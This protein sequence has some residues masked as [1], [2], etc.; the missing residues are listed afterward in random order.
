M[1]AWIIATLGL[2]SCMSEADLST[3]TDDVTVP[4]QRGTDRASA[5][6]VAEA[7]NLKT[8]HGVKWTGVYIGGP[9]SAGSGWTKAQVTAI[10]NATGWTF[11]PTYVG[12]QSSA[13]CGAHTLTQAQGT[14]D[15]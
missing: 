9:C 5:F 6:S 1:R 4:V 3:A 15:G 11:M 14:A 2:A 8:N 7:T 12:Q 13:I 10:A